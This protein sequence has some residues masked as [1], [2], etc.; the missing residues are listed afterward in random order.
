MPAGKTLHAE[1]G[2]ALEARIAELEAENAR[3]KEQAATLDAELSQM[4][5]D[6]KTANN[7]EAIKARNAASAA[8]LNDPVTTVPQRAEPAPPLETQAEVE[9]L[10]SRITNLERSLAESHNLR[11]AAQGD[12]MRAEHEIAARERAV[13]E[14][15]A[16]SER[17]KMT[18]ME[19]E[20][21]IVELTAE[22]ECLRSD[23][24]Q[25]Q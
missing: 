22:I 7:L 11:A 23:L 15:Q 6:I 14:G 21:R 17:A 9:T 8:F 10:R 13:R 5:E 1:N 25:R 3:L 2:T 12:L 4:T 18:L 16:A 20:H 19:R 24:R